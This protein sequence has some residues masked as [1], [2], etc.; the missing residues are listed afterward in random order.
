M[1]LSQSCS[2]TIDEVLQIWFIT[3]VLTTQKRNAIGKLKVLFNSYVKIRKNKSCRTERYLKLETDLVNKINKLFDVAHAD[4]ERLIKIKQDINFLQDK[5]EKRKMVLGE[6]DL[7]FK[8]REQKRVYRH[9][10]E[11]HRPIQTLA[12]QNKTLAPKP[13]R[14]IDNSLFIA[15]LDCT[16]TTSVQAMHI[17]VPVLKA[18]GI[19]IKDMTPSA[20][21]IY[22]ARKTIRKSIVQNIQETFVPN[23]PVFFRTAQI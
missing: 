7:E 20:S 14:V 19:D 8:E 12:K 3:N 23:T 9:F 2:N 10:Q 6:E 17:V 1:E 4:C 5:R 15:S 13:H 11:G 18:V 16:K 21:S 22:R